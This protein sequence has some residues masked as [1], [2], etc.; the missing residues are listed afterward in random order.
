MARGR[1]FW[2]KRLIMRSG[3]SVRA[4][5]TMVGS[6]AERDADDPHRQCCCGGAARLQ[7]AETICRMARLGRN[8]GR[9]WTTAVRAL[10]TAATG[11][12]AVETDLCRRGERFPGGLVAPLL[13]GGTHRAIKHARRIRFNNVNRGD[14]ASRVDL[15]PCA[16]R[17]AL[18]VNAAWKAGLNPIDQLDFTHYGRRRSCCGRGRRCS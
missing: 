13:Q 14:V 8:C 1:G 2:R 5:P 15:Q 4:P 18:C 12:L 9:V 3:F 7:S 10:R 17:A 16:H 6:E 11:L